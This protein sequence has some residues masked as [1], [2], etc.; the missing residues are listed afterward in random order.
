[1]RFYGIN[2][3]ILIKIEC[4][5]PAMTRGFLHISRCLLNFTS[6]NQQGQFKDPAVFISITL[7]HNDPRKRKCLRKNCKL[8]VKH[9][10]FSE[11]L[12]SRHR[13]DECL[14][15]LCHLHQLLNHI[16]QKSADPKIPWMLTSTSGALF[17][18]EPPPPAPPRV[19]FTLSE[20]ITAPK[21]HVEGQPESV[22]V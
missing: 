4:E 12:I 17:L 20:I 3:M 5:S 1:M 2:N 7:K 8:S 11:A 21:Q 22:G 16:H 9:H 6:C 19:S 14:I 15:K 18:F 10:F 13:S